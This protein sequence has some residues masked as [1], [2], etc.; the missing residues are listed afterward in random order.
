MQNVHGIKLFVLCRS[1]C[2][3]DTTGDIWHVNR[4]QK[5]WISDISDNGKFHQ[6]EIVRMPKQDDTAPRASKVR[7]R[8]NV[9]RSVENP[10]KIS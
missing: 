8:K 1:K 7:S 4:V 6:M 2:G 3:I 9:Q 10:S 5:F